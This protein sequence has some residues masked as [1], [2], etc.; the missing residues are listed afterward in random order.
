MKIKDVIQEDSDMG[1]VTSSGAV[2]T[3]PGQIGGMIKRSPLVGQGIYAV[4][5]EGERSPMYKD[6]VKKDRIRSL[7]NLIQIYTEKGNSIK[8]KELT[9]ELKRLNS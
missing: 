2:A 5:K 3:V 9:A 4:Q 7:V 8:V 6:S 1:G